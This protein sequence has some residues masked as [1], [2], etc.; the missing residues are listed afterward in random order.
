MVEKYPFPVSY[1]G[2]YYK[3]TG[4]TI[5]ELT[6]IELDKMILEAK[7]LGQMGDTVGLIPLAAG[8]LAAFI[9]VFFALAFLMKIIRKGQLEWFAAY[10]IPAGILGMIFF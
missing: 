2:K 4:S 8:C 5:Q 3:R 10:L 7:D 6:G 9:S 1:H